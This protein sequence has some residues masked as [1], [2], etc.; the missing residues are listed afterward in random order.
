M[1]KYHHLMTHCKF[2]LAEKCAAKVNMMFGYEILSGY[3]LLQAVKNDW[4]GLLPP[5]HGLPSRLPDDEMELLANVV[6]TCETIEQV[7]CVAERMERGQ[8]ISI[9]AKIVNEHLES[10]GEEPV[11]EQSL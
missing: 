1:V 10:V 2:S 6:F 11:N 3:Q 5:K 9:L 4:V 7:N 8:T